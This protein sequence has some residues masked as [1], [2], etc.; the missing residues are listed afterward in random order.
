MA[1]TTFVGLR[2]MPVMATARRAMLRQSPVITAMRFASSN[3]AARAE[4]AVHKFAWAETEMPPPSPGR[5]IIGRSANFDVTERQGQYER[6]SWLFKFLGYMNQDDQLFTDSNCVFQSCVNQSAHRGFYRALQLAPN[7]RGQQA[8]LLA[9]VWMVHRR[10][11]LE[12]ENGK[13]MQE[14]LFDRLWEETVVR[15]RFMNVSELTVN[16]HLAEVQQLCFNALISYDRGLKDSPAA[17]QSTIAQHLLE[18]DSA[19]GQRIA[20]KLVEYLKREMKNLDKLD[21]KYLLKG[22]IP[23]GPHVAATTSTP[24]LEHED[25]Y[26]II[27]EQVGNWRAALDNRGKLYYWNLSTRYSVWDRPTG[28]DLNKGLEQQQQQE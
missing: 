15:I 7:F 25:E 22:T 26:T 5:G 17:F 11:A 9:H 18:D 19:A 4:T 16:K 20:S 28:G 13:V 21:A 6:W 2:A 1:L 14:L 10:L 23:W 24:P 3:A 27:G 8:L 12:G